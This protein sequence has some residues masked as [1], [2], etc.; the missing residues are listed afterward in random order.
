[1]DTLGVESFGCAQSL[2]FIATH[3]RSPVSQRVRAM[4]SAGAASSQP[5]GE[6]D[7]VEFVQVVVARGSVCGGDGK[8]RVA[9][10]TR[11]VSRSMLDD[12]ARSAG[13]VL[14]GV[15]G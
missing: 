7:D 15:E 3:Q 4:K 13:G 14:E 6:A 11:V 2:A 10:S 5:S 12:R 8:A 1:M 9:P